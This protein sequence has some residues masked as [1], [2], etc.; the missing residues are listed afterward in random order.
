VDSCC[1]QYAY[2]EILSRIADDRLCGIRVDD[3][4]PVVVDGNGRTMYAV[5]AD[6]EDYTAAAIRYQHRFRSARG[7][8]GGQCPR[9]TGTLKVC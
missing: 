6:I 1:I 4:G 7:A 9:V 3:I 2:W 8:P 5:D